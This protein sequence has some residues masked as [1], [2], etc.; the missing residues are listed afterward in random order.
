M[1]AFDGQAASRVRCL[2]VFVG[3]NGATVESSLRNVLGR[4]DAFDGRVE[5]WVE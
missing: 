2:G 3:S 1:L 4:I 5:N